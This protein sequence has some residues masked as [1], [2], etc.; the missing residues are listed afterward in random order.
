VRFMTKQEVRECYGQSVYQ[1]RLA[2]AQHLF[3]QGESAREALAKADQFVAALHA[4]SF[5][6]LTTKS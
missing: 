1:I 6:E 3:C 4:E 5:Q 2:I